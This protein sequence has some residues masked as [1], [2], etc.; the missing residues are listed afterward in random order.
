M[1]YL[2]AFINSPACGLSQPCKSLEKDLASGYRFA[3]LLV[4]QKVLPAESLTSLRDVPDDLDQCLHNYDTVCKGL[5]TLGVS[6]KRAV[7]GKCISGH[8]GAA[9]SLLMP[10]KKALAARGQPPAP[11]VE[12]STATSRYKKFTREPLT[13]WGSDD[14]MQRTMDS[15]KPEQWNLIDMD[16]THHATTQHAARGTR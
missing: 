1:S 16:G 14:F 15:R 11:P 12:L 10:V 5:D 13:D 6:Y 2:L 3:E 9:A 7:I 4:H 8:R